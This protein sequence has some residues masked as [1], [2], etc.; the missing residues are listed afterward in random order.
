MPDDYGSYRPQKPISRRLKVSHGTNKPRNSREQESKF[1]PEG[2]STIKRGDR[3]G[4]LWAKRKQLKDSLGTVETSSLYEP[5]ELW[6]EN[7]DDDY[8]ESAVVS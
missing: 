1:K 4:T 5:D 8:S 3:T 7:P 2:P 6:F